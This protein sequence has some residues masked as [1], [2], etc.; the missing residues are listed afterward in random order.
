MFGLLRDVHLWSSVE[1]QLAGLGSL[2]LILHRFSEL[3]RHHECLVEGGESS[4][5]LPIA[6]VL[7]SSGVGRAHQQQF[8]LEDEN[9]PQSATCLQCVSSVAARKVLAEPD[10]PE[11][12]SLPRPLSLKNC[13]RLPQSDRSA[14]DKDTDY[15][16]ACKEDRQP[17]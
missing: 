4:R 15:E 2:P 16:N 11:G 13:S 14:R 1:Q 9:L 10:Q 8:F 12:T 3:S 6:R 5:H 7:N 17:K